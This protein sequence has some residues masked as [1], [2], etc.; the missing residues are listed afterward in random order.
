MIIVKEAV[1][2]N[3]KKE[4]AKALTLF[5]SD[6][7]LCVY[8]YW[9]NGKCVG[10]SWLDL[11][12]PHYL[13][14]EYYDKSAAIVKAIYESF[15]ELFKIKPY[16]TARISTDNFKSL[17]MT[18]QLG[19]YTLYTLDNCSVVEISKASWRFKKRYPFN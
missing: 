4:I 2:L 10:A 18:K 19:F 13:S 6:N 5:S 11:T 16:L 15:K 12:Y 7:C 3:E 14:M 9:K 17:K 8:G 1:T